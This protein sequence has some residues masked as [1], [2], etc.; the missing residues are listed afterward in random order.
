MPRGPLRDMLAFDLLEEPTWAACTL[1]DHVRDEAGEAEMLRAYDC[2]I[3]LLH[4][5]RCEAAPVCEP[6]GRAW[7]TDSSTS[8]RF[9]VVVSLR[10][11]GH[12][13]ISNPDVGFGVDDANAS[14]ELL[15]G[16]PREYL[17]N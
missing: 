1:F 10:R 12:I 9:R 15:S 8:K 6:L 2:A 14:I 5:A 7:V 17:L 16:L 3:L 4:T 11:T 13:V